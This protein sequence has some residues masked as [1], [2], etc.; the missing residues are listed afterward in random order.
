MKKF[1]T[2]YK[3]V[4]LINSK[5]YIGKHETDDPYDRYLGSG[6]LLQAAI[7]KVWV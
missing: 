5:Y 3:T 1:Y 7:K 2:I 6:I 4:N